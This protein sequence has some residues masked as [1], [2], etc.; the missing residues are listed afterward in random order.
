MHGPASPT[1]PPQGITGTHPLHTHKR[2]LGTQHHFSFPL[3][4][5]AAFIRTLC[6]VKTGQS[7]IVSSKYLSRTS[8]S[9]SR[10]KSRPDHQVR[11]I[12][13]CTIRLVAVALSRWCAGHSKQIAPIHTHTPSPKVPRPYCFLS[14]KPLAIY[15]AFIG[16]HCQD[17]TVHMIFCSPV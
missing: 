6:A 13:P 3:Y 5:Q 7:T 9:L 12:N 14:Y 8:I 16:F 15:F 1:F 11:G 17:Q 4:I 10:A 2:Y